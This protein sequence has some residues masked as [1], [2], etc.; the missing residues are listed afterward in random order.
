MVIVV[1]TSVFVAALLGPEG[2]SREVLRQCLAGKHQPLMGTALFCEY[3]ALLSREGLFRR[4]LLARA[5]REDLL[6]A[7]LSVCR[8]TRIY[9][10]WR[11]NIPDEGDNHIVELAVAG[12]AEAIVTR[13]PRDFRTPE[14]WFPGLRVLGPEALIK[15]V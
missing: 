15:E 7:F 2:P 1:D 10:R 5:E 11:P 9:Y 14:L 6:D 4:C 12:S 8:W 3:E 13:N